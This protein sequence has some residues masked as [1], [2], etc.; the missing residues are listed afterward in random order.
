MT[1]KKNVPPI[2]LDD[3]DRAIL[4]LLKDDGRV[5]FSR[6]A[7]QLGVSAGMVRQR[8]QRLTDNGVLQF[9]A[10]TNPLK[11]GYHTMALIGVK[12]DGQRLKEIARQIAAFD[13]VIYL[14]ITSSTYDLLV[15]VTCYD[16]THLLEFLTEKLNSVE[17]VRD[18]EAFIYLDIVKEI[19]TWESPEIPA[20]IKPAGE[21]EF[22]DT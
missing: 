11:I 2:P 21:A 22:V 17:G 15:E 20:I 18:T 6:V 9:V 8:T 13:E 1:I 4:K 14:V 12:A 10:V 5:P 3:A 7:E 16:N 19:Y